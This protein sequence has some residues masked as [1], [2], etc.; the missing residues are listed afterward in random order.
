MLGA[1]PIEGKATG[2]VTFKSVHSIHFKTRSALDAME[3]TRC[4][5]PVGAQGPM[6]PPG[7][8]GCAGVGL[9]AGVP[10]Y[11]VVLMLA[12]RSAAPL[13]ERAAQEIRS[14]ARLLPYVTDEPLSGTYECATVESLTTAKRVVDTRGT[15]AKPGFDDLLCVMR[16]VTGMASMTPAELARYG[17]GEDDEI[18]LD[19]VDE[20]EVVT[21]ADREAA[22]TT[23]SVWSTVIEDAPWVRL[24]IVLFEDDVE[25]NAHLVKDAL[26]SLAR[27]L[28]YAMPKPDDDRFMQRV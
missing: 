13:F 23:R 26:L 5:G 27:D 1:L 16:E 4:K 11:V 20:R 25:R 6:G 9:G 19:F 3:R 18:N 24:K 12:P 21:D 22:I 15:F 17:S 10:A 28:P 7:S 2:C 8:A 14:S